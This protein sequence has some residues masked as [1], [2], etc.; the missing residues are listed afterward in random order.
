ML[1][2]SQHF[3]FLAFTNYGGPLRLSGR[4]LIIEFLLFRGR[5][6]RRSASLM[7]T[8]SRQE[9]V[10]FNAAASVRAAFDESKHALGRRRTAAADEKCEVGRNLN[11]IERT[12][13]SQI[14][15]A[16]PMIQSLYQCHITVV[17]SK[18]LSLN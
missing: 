3:Y 13:F 14:Y 9:V 10:S 15:L 11:H 18:K 12:R 6:F 1:R 8:Q 17:I 4:F 16:S 5:E 2:P 7:S